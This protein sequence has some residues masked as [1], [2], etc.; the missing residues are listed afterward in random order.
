MRRC[1]YCNV[2]LVRYDQPSPR[3][4]NVTVPPNGRTRDHLIPKVRGGKAVPD[5]T[6][7]CCVNCNQ[8]KGR[9]TSNEFKA[10]MMYRQ[11]MIGDDELIHFKFPGEK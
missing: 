8:D 6:V 11:G 3:R 4:K 10:I 7:N 5:N 9:L 2:V 1:Y